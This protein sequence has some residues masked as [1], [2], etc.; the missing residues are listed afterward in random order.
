MIPVSEDY[1]AAID[2]SGPALKCEVEIYF[3]GDDQ[4]PVV[5]T[6]DDISRLS[7]LEEVSAES[8]NPLGLVSS[9]ELT[10][11][12]NNKDWSFTP[13]NSDGPYYGKLRPNT[14]IK[15]RL[16]VEIAPETVE[17]VPLGVFRTGDWSAP[18]DDVEA[19]V[20]CQ[21]RLS[22]IGEKN[23]PMM[24]VQRNTAIYGMFE[25]LFQALGMAPD[26]YSID[27][28]LQ[29]K[30]KLGWLPK[31]KVQ[32]TLQTLAV[33]GN[34][35]VTADR[36]GRIRVRS[37]FAA[38]DPVATL[39]E[40]NQLVRVDNPLQYQD[41]YSAVN[42]NY[43]TPIIQPSSSVLKVDSVVIP[44]GGL[45]LRDL[46]FSDPVYSVDQVR[47]LGARTSK[48][49]RIEY[50]S[51]SINI[52]IA[53]PETR[54]ETVAV[55]VIGRVIKDT[56]ASHIVEDPEA[57]ATV[58]RK[59]LTVDNY[60]IQ[61]R[62]TAK[63]YAVALLFLLKDP[64]ATYEGKIVGDPALEAGDIVELSSETARLGTVP[65]VLNRIS[66]DF[67]GGIEA[68]IN[69]RKQLTPI[70]WT[71]VSPGLAA[72]MPRQLAQPVVDWTFISPGLAIQMRR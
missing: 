72:Q 7:L 57:V 45:T 44:H 61:G 21:N 63:E 9:G 4:P 31:G 55:E 38:G 53:N 56:K 54:S 23:I 10:V 24:P 50:G 41:I 37:N 66:M 16:G 60:L 14:L 27:T 59:E 17:Y 70:D 65:V 47:L 35:S 22:D 58:G 25:S 15:A 26:E 5:F 28:S 39:A 33:A 19:T 13:T 32:T 34:C 30:I 3:D 49:D 1:R 46:E 40:D 6:Q 18:S 43:C 62:D 71:F 11:R 12:L 51:G 68:D 29:Q 2:G 69:C 67:D 20:T 64:L 36:Y 52:G 48:V 42:V 8:S